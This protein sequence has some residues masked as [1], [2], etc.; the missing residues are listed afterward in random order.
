VDHSLAPSMAPHRGG[1]Y[2]AKRL[3]PAS[4]TVPAAATDQQH[5]DDNDQ[6]CRGIHIALLGMKR[7]SRWTKARRLSMLA[8]DAK[9]INHWRR[10]CKKQS[11]TPDRSLR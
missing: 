8:S 7:C 4:A 6:K 11:Q 9:A 10:D 2:R 5:N 1:S 3:V